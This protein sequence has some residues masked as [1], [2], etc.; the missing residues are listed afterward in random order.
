MIKQIM[1]YLERIGADQLTFRK[2]GKGGYAHLNIQVEEL[3]DFNQS[4][5][6]AV[7]SFML[8]DAIVTDENLDYNTLETLRNVY[9]YG[10]NDKSGFVDECCPNCG[11]Q[12]GEYE[13]TCQGGSPDKNKR[14]CLR[15]DCTWYGYEV[16]ADLV[17]RY[18][19][20]QM[21]KKDDNV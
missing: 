20:A 16:T 18:I 1:Q 13:V 8:N 12:A 11:A 6:V 17:R 7:S 2:V 14:V 19:M 21:E 15:C 10:M 5:Y 3:N 9:N 4:G